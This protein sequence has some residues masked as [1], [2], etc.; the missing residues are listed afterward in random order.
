MLCYF[1]T[2]LSSIVGSVLTGF[3]TMRKANALYQYSGSLLP[4][5]VVVHWFR[6]GNCAA[7]RSVV[8]SLRIE[9]EMHS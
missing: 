9:N 5:P 8:I 1:F 3:A 6:R 7:S 4:V 2:S